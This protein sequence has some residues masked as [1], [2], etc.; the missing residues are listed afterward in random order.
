MNLTRAF[1]A[2]AVLLGASATFQAVV[3]SSVSSSAAVVEEDPTLSSSV[4]PDA[5]ASVDT[6][7]H[8]PSGPLSATMETYEMRRLERHDEMRARGLLVGDDDAA[9]DSDSLSPEED[10]SDLLSSGT[11]SARRLMSPVGGDFEP[12]G[13]NEGLVNVTACSDF[14]A[15]LPVPASGPLVVPCG[16]CYVVDAGTPRD[17]DLS[18]TSGLDIQGRLTIPQ[19]AGITITT[20]A[21]YLQGELEVQSDAEITAANRAVKFV[22]T[23]TAAQTFVPADTNSGRCGAGGCAVGTK[24]FLVAG[25][26]LNIDAMPP[27]CPTWTHLKSY[28][29]ASVT[30]LDEHKV[31]RYTS[32][33]AGCTADLIDN[34]FQI[35]GDGT[36]GWDGDK[37]AEVDIMADSTM[38]VHD[39]K[40]VWQGP[41]NDITWLKG[42]LVSGIDYLFTAKVML[43]KEGITGTDTPTTCVGTGSKCL[44]VQTK[45]RDAADRNHDVTMNWETQKTAPNY[46]VWHDFESTINFDPAWGIETAKYIVLKFQGPEADVEMKVDVASLRLPDPASF[47]ASCSDM[48]PNGDQ[49]G[50]GPSP[51]PMRI[52][53][54]RYPPVP[55]PES[56]GGNPRLVSRHETVNGNETNTY[57]SL[58]GKYYDWQGP[59][60]REIPPICVQ[61]RSVYRV[62]FRIHLHSTPKEQGGWGKFQPYVDLYAFYYGE[63]NGH[64]GYHHY[65]SRRLVTCEPIDE[66]DGWVT[67]SQ[68]VVI[69]DKTDG[70]RKFTEADWYRWDLRI[71]GKHDGGYKTSKDDF[72]YD[73]IQFKLL[74]GNVEG[75]IVPTEAVQGCWGPGSEIAITSHTLRFEDSQ[76]ATIKNVTAGP[77]PGTSKLIIDGGIVPATTT[78]EAEA[79]LDGTTF[80]AEIA[81]LSRNVEIHSDNQDDSRPSE[82][83]AARQGGY[84]QVT[85]TPT[86]QQKFSGVELRYMGQ[87]KNADRFPLHLH[88]CRD[89]RSLIEKNTVR[90]SYSRGIVI[91]GTDNTTISE[92]VAYKTRGNTFVLVD[93]TETDN[94]FYKNLGA[95]TLGTGDWWWHGNRVDGSHDQDD[96]WPNT[97]FTR[98]PDN[99]WIGNVAAG[100]RRAGFYLGLHWTVNYESKASGM[101]GRPR[102]FGI[103]QFEGN[104]VHSNHDYGIEIRDFEPAKDRTTGQMTGDWSGAFYDTDVYKN[105]YMGLKIEYCRDVLFDG[106][107]FVDNRIGIYTYRNNGIALRNLKIRGE[108]DEFNGVASSQNAERFCHDPHSNNPKDATPMGIYWMTYNRWGHDR[109]N[110]LTGLDI[111]GFGDE[112]NPGCTGGTGLYIRSQSSGTISEGGSPHFSFKTTF[113]A[114]TTIAGDVETLIG[115]NRRLVAAASDVSMINACYG[116]DK[117]GVDDILMDIDDGA[118]VNGIVGPGVVISNTP[119]MMNMIQAFSP[120]IT[121]TEF[122]ESCVAIC[123]QTCVRQVEF[124]VEK[125]SSKDM[126]MVITNNADNSTVAV[127]GII[128]LGDDQLHRGRDRYFY[129]A[130]P[131]GDFTVAFRDTSSNGNGNVGYPTYVIEKWEDAP[132]CAGHVNPGDVTVDEG[133]D[134]VEGWDAYCSELIRNGDAESG[135][136]EPWNHNGNGKVELVPGGGVDGSNAVQLKSRSRD[137]GGFGMYLDQRCVRRNLGKMY[138]IKADIRLFEKSDGTT[139]RSCNPNDHRTDTGCP[140]ILFEKYYRQSWAKE[141]MDRIDSTS[142]SSYYPFAEVVR[143]VDP[144]GF[145][146]IHG[147]MTFTDDHLDSESTFLSI[148]NVNAN[149]NIVIDNLSMKPFGAF[150]S[151][152]ASSCDDLTTNGGLEIGDARYWDTFGSEKEMV[153]VPG[154]GGA[155]DLAIKMLGRTSTHHS[156]MQTLKRGCMKSGER[157]IAEVK[158]KMTDSGGNAVSCVPQTEESYKHRTG[159]KCPEIRAH[160]EGNGIWGYMTMGNVVLPTRSEGWNIAKGAFYAL[161]NQIN[162]HRLRAWLEDEPTTY[163]I[164][165]DDFHIKPVPLDEACS[166]LVLNPNFEDDLSFWRSWRRHDG[167]IE[168]LDGGGIISRQR[169]HYEAG[170]RQLIEHRCFSVGDEYIVTGSF[171][172][173][174]ATGHGAS[175]DP[176]QDQGWRQKTNCPSIHLKASGCTVN[177]VSGQDWNKWLRTVEFKKNGWKPDDFNDFKFTLSVDKILASCTGAEIYV[178]DI[179]PEFEILAKSVSFNAKTKSPTLEPTL[180][181]TTAPTTTPTAA[182]TAPTAAPTSQPTMNETAVP[183]VGDS[184][185]IGDGNVPIAL[186]KAGSDVITTLSAVTLDNGTESFVVPIARSYNDHGWE[187]EPGGI[188]EDK[189]HDLD[190]NCYFEACEIDLPGLDPG[191]QYKL[192]SSEASSRYT[193]P[194]LNANDNIVA[195]FLESATFGPTQADI[196]IINGVS[197]T[198]RRLAV[199]DNIN[200]WIVNQMDE[201]ITPATSHREYW[202]ARAN[203]RWPVPEE[204]GRAGNPCKAGSRWRK[205]AFTGKDAFDSDF[206]HYMSVFP[207]SESSICHSH[208]GH[209]NDMMEAFD[210]SGLTD[211]TSCSHHGMMDHV[212]YSGHCVSPYCAPAT[213]PVDGVVQ[214]GEGAL[215]PNYEG[216]YYDFSS[217]SVKPSGLVPG[218]TYTF[219]RTEDSTHPFAIKG[220]PNLRANAANVGPT[221]ESFTYTIPNDHHVE[222]KF[223]EYV[224]PSHPNMRHSL[225]PV[226]DHY[227]LMYDG[228]PRTIVAGLKSPT[229]SSLLYEISR[230]PSSTSDIHIRPA[231]GGSEQKLLSSNPEVSFEVFREYECSPG[232]TVQLPS[233]YSFVDNGNNRNGDIVIGSDVDD[234]LCASLPDI[235]DEGDPPI[236]GKMDDGSMWVFD[237]RLILESNTVESPLQ[238]GGG[239]VSLETADK[240]KCS[241]V[242]RT[243]LNEDNCT[244]STQ[245]SACNVGISVD[246]TFELNDDNIKQINTLTGRYVYALEGLVVTDAYGNETNH[247]CTPNFR[248]RWLKGAD[249]ACVDPTPLDNATRT[250]VTAFLEGNERDTNPFMRDVIF[251]GDGSLPCDLN[252]PLGTK[253]QVGNDCWTHVHSDHLSVYDMTYW[254]LPD[255]H[256]GNMHAEMR[257]AENPIKKWMDSSDSARLVFPSS[258]PLTGTTNPMTDMPFELDHP[259]LRWEVHH[260]KFDYVG[261]FGDSTDFKDLPTGLRTAEVAE[262]Y[263]ATFN[264]GSSNVL[265][266]GSPGEIANN[267]SLGSLFDVTASAMRDTTS[268]SDLARQRENVWTTIAVES[269]DQLRQRMAWALSQILVIV[270]DGIPSQDRNTEMFLQYYDIMVRNAFGNYFDILKEISYSPLMAMHLTYLR[271][272]STAYEWQANRIVAFADENYAREVM[273]LFTIGLIRLNMDGSP[274]RDPVTD[275]PVATYTNDHITSFAKAWTGFD[276]QL[277]RGN[278]EDYLTDGNKIDP[279]RIVPE[280]RDRFPKTDLND[281]YVG[282]GYPRCSDI[283]TGMFLNEGAT[284]RLIGGSNL[285]E[286]VEDPI[287]FATDTT[288][289]KFVLPSTSQLK[290]ALCVA[291]LGGCKYPN[292]VVLAKSLN[293]TDGTL[294]GT[295]N[296]CDVDTVRTVQVDEGLFYEYVPPACVQQA[297]YPNPVKLSG[298]RKPP[299]VEDW[300]GNTCADPRLP[301]AGEACCNT[302]S[303]SLVFRANAY[304]GERMTFVKAQERCES[305]GPDWNNCQKY[306]DETMTFD[307]EGDDIYKTYYHWG[308]DGDVASDTCEIHAKIDAEGNVAMVYITG[309][310][311]VEYVQLDSRSNFPAYWEGGEFP[312]PENNCGGG[313]DGLCRAQSALAAGGAAACECGVTVD[314]SQ[315]FNTMPPSADAI[316]SRLKI[317]AMI[318]ASYGAGVYSSRDVNDFV[319]HEK[320]G[321][322]KDTIFEINDTKKSRTLYFM[323]V[324]STVHIDS[325]S[326]RNPP[327]FMSL[328]PSET[329]LRD[330]QHETDAVLA[331]YFYQDT[332]APFVSIRLIQRFGISNPSPRYI[333]AVAT[334]FSTGFYDSDGVRF[335]KRVYGDLE[336]TAAAILLDRE[337]RDVLLDNDP[338]FGSL[339]EPLVKIIGLMRSMEY[340]AEP[341]EPLVEFDKMESRIGEMAHEHHSVFSF[342]LPEYEPDGRIAS[343][344]LSAPESQLM[345]MPKIVELQNGLYSLI[346]NGLKR[347]NFEGYNYGFAPSDSKLGELTFD[348]TT[349]DGSIVID[350]LSTLLTAGRLSAENRAIIYDAY[351][352]KYFEEGDADEALKLAMQLVVSSPE[353]HSTQTPT[354]KGAPR[355]KVDAMEGR[356]AVT[357]KAIVYIMLTGGADSYSFLVPLS[358]SEALNNATATLVNG[359]TAREQYVAI[360]QGVALAPEKLLPIDGGNDVYSGHP[361]PCETFGIHENFPIMRDLYTGFG[362][363][364]APSGLWFA[365]TG[366]LTK[367][368]TKENYREVSAVTQLFAHNTQQDCTRRVDHFQLERGTGVLGRMADALHGTKYITSGIS[369]RD[370]TV[371]LAGTPGYSP[372]Y[373]IVGTNAGSTQFNPDPTDASM[374]DKIFDLNNATTADSG[375]F[376]ETW[377]AKS[378][379]AINLNE[380][381]SELLKSSSDSNQLTAPFDC[382]DLCNKLKVIA[383]FIKSAGNPR[384]VHREMFY[385]TTGGWD[386]HSMVETGLISRLSHVNEAI[387]QFVTELKAQGK[388]DQVVIIETSDFARTLDPNGNAGVDHGW[389]GNYF[390]IGGD[391]KGGQIVNRYPNDILNPD[392]SR[393]PSNVGRGRMI[394]SM[395]WDSVWHALAQWMGVE[396]AEMDKVLPNKDAFPADS[397]LDATDLFH[398]NVRRERKALRK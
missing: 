233:T 264:A 117:F 194:A 58:V 183:D 277:Q 95:L 364:E 27:A 51:Y 92:N 199:E 34:S 123:A 19:G 14:S 125:E 215:D 335:G 229:N 312:S 353:F 164:T 297:F 151:S 175:C 383:Q 345:D 276:L 355:T 157:Y 162:A 226:L 384:K 124:R 217:G 111:A 20:P 303:G 57:T 71:H 101:R 332:T 232:Q 349:T 115:S 33:P 397:F 89:S 377:A 5:A 119:K 168:Y 387:S 249:Q 64:L 53:H 104:V 259:I 35:G 25:G 253:I 271:S 394:P 391:V 7:M 152:D 22:L 386:M 28:T 165:M 337:A 136:L 80:A 260:S 363:A 382:G 211:G 268:S 307:P 77:I 311:T 323:N 238:D 159:I 118:S 317:G 147:I 294:S 130:L 133:A 236:F 231:G 102:N 213:A 93:G 100:S 116:Q 313:L 300:L 370:S 185:Y 357:Y 398:G 282:D 373:R 342:F 392:G 98:T 180:P 256:P 172:L 341:N 379:D 278:T 288:I 177:G 66:G 248:S 170:F 244:L 305:L 99:K 68:D 112:T 187:K 304:D 395:A 148:R 366:V 196:D 334:A 182:P 347:N 145:S 343:A 161:D 318:P 132:T 85:H 179:N 120:G 359:A 290:E 254:S 127:D 137:W 306:E 42:C 246:A 143:G 90:D 173:Q 261:R 220:C 330:A 242:P 114:E 221:G 134:P 142:W 272:T 201:T 222:A 167:R 110:E 65:D 251:P 1:A 372:Q 393:G 163:D 298:K 322:N 43:T 45:I 72:D 186:A 208:A 291:E 356:S 135:S 279:M 314:D 150:D 266:C 333:E 293:C 352:E 88:Q 78:Q 378:I 376:A 360:R 280:W 327:H 258:H 105:R 354:L 320:N 329:N 153:L 189:M 375:F 140:E 70:S 39:R 31:A 190:W 24:P 122:A 36:V 204:V 156:P 197:G 241:N 191:R 149:A 210:C 108:S 389:G 62:S 141:S 227:V 346:K 336:A 59:T 388:Y 310:N 281:G 198:R 171:K 273:Q 262:N 46:N 109:R 269:K 247:F 169:E 326:F 158:F 49:E 200:S 17:L 350:K 91:Q 396:E 228:F 263:G 103:G 37:G 97:F 166:N 325:Y 82:V 113:G 240:T 214:V 274:V 385:A 340:D 121:C 321:F 21:V 368:V 296:E 351:K 223:V 41:T 374:Q 61:S 3:A 219:N 348:P 192:S 73:D 301:V 252:S 26:R 50:N 30:L 235:V 160:H 257:G 292:K 2:L 176:I 369:I 339:R 358:C 209:E 381:M 202:R 96:R 12:L 275:M 9:E 83:P 309:G 184:W 79:N 245:A 188:V 178:Y 390:M 250:T 181:V 87:D 234:L 86:V 174:N 6:S 362:G 338:S 371:T 56:W 40:A 75:L 11:N 55:M 316:M 206:P 285:P 225:I 205:Y 289:K 195:R 4:M 128:Y 15:L 8:A 32:P 380:Q 224:C 74:Q 155:G 23:G 265:V 69:L 324:E 331:S 131:E 284:Y 139:P 126:Q 237:P 63:R 308:W 38:V 287:E 107:T 319:V 84:V 154:A 29:A 54:H 243:F 67:C 138:E 299:E 302:L 295:G 270:K 18:G 144:S 129:A 16:A 344:A 230:R 203:P 218:K 44:K 361:Q 10:D 207:V 193:D 315:A 52:N 212:C 13:C 328:V 283:P 146:T 94:L 267:A 48:I 255:T 76:V 365:N 106:G 286:L 60:F 216:H 367:P 239:A 47:V 81:L